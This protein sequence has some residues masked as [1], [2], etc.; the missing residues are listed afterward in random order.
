[1]NR[2]SLLKCVAA[3]IVAP[4]AITQI[5]RP[6]SI[7]MLP[8]TQN[9]GEIDDLAYFRNNLFTK[10]SFPRNVYESKKPA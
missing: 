3:A 1:M 2:R 6:T 10:F 4:A 5:I 9:L 7:E 8:G